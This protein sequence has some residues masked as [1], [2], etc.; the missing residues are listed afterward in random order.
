MSKEERANFNI[1]KGHRQR[2]KQRFLA[3]P[4]AIHDYELLELILFSA[5]PRKD[6]KPLAKNLIKHYKTF[7][8][9]INNDIDKL[10]EF[11]EVTPAVMTSFEIIK[12]AVKH[13]LKQEI[14]ERPL[15]SNWNSLMDYL[16]AS[17][18]SLPRE[19]FRVLF[20]NSK[21]YL[22]ADEAQE[23]GTVDHTVVYPREIVKRALFHEAT[24]IILAHN[25][26]SGVPNPSKADVELTMKLS[27][28]CNS[29][30]VVIHDHIV[31]TSN[32][33]YSFKTNNLL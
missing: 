14:I 8:R 25:H 28:A 13:I 33:V 23:V 20:L 6:V 18:G 9:V 12:Q 26:P 24:A 32:D 16:R 22:I 15:L 17:M 2:L 1:Y 19:Q 27:E 31:V 21:N 3:N 29:I 7:A 4:Q 5:I 11:P 10:E 30:G